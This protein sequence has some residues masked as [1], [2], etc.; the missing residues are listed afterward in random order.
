MASGPC[1]CAA[2]SWSERP[3]A[4]LS[5]NPARSLPASLASAV[6]PAQAVEDALGEVLVAA[7]LLEQSPHHAHAVR[8][9]VSTVSRIVV[10]TNLGIL[11][12]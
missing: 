3:R 4:A 10:T 7:H 1:G 11:F 6:L 12:M 9:R 2:I 8:F 5:G